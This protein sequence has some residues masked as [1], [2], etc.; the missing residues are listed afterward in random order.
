MGRGKKKEGGR[1]RKKE[2]GR[3][4]E[5][6]VGKGN[7]EAGGRGKKEE[8]GRGRKKE[9]GWGKKEKCEKRSKGEGSPFEM[10]VLSQDE[11]IK[12]KEARLAKAT[13]DSCHQHDQQWNNQHHSV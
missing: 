10:Y 4:K 8:G 7:K 5:K 9:G 13:E 1:G 6:K 3:G 11:E 2:G 12:E